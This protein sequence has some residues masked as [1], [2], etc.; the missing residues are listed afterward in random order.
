MGTLASEKEKKHICTGLLA[1]VDAGKTTLSEA[2]LYVGGMIRKLGRV[3]RGD[4]YLDTYE[5]EKKR[6]I[7]IFSKQARLLWDGMEMTILDTPGHVDFSAEMERVL[8]VL[9]Y[10]IL[11]I[12]GS[13]GVQGHTRTLWRLLA[14]YQVPV[15]LFI[16]KMDLAEGRKEALLQELRD[17]LGGNFVDF[18]EV[19]T[20]AF[21]EE[22]AVSGEAELEEFLETGM[23]SDEAIQDRIETRDL[24]PCFFGSALKNQGVEELLR[25][26]ERYGKRQQYPETFGARVFKIARD[27]QG[28]RLTYLKITGGTLKVKDVIGEEKVNQ[29]R[30]YSGERFETVSE[31]GAGCICAVTGLLKT[32]PGQGIGSCETGVEPALEPVLTYRIELPEE[33]D[34]AAMLPK[35]IQL[36]EEEPELHIAWEEEKKEIH[37][38]IMGEIQMEILKNLIAERFGVEIRFG[39]RSIVYKETIADTVEGVGHYEPLRHYAEVHLLLEPGER[40]SGLVFGSACSEDI[41]DKNWQRLVMTHLE[42][43][44]HRGVLMGAP[45]TDMKITLMSGRAHVKHTE[46]GDFRQSVYRAVRHGLRQAQSVLL[47][48]IY[49]FRLTVPERMVGRAMTDLE[50]RGGVFEAPLIEQGCAVLT[51]TAPVSLLDGYQTEVTAY[52]GG[53]GQLLCTL[54]GYGPCHNTEEVL[55]AAGYDPDTDSDNPCGSVFCSHGAGFVVPWDEV[56][57][58]MHLESCLGNRAGK[59]RAADEIRNGARTSDGRDS[60]SASAGSEESWIGTDEIDAILARTYNANKKEEGRR[61]WGNPRKAAASAGGSP[62][63][64]SRGEKALK[65]AEKKESR[66]LPEYL[67]V[68]G[69]NIIFAWDELKEMA[70]VNIDSARG[71]LQ[72]ILCDYQGS[73]GVEVIVVFDAYRVQ[74]HP[75]ELFDYHNIHVVFTKEA[76]TADQYIEKFAHENGRKYRVTVAT[77]DHLEQIIIR[78]QGCGLYSAGDLKKEIERVRAQVQETYGTAGG[79]SAIRPEGSRNYLLDSV[80]EEVLSQV[81][82]SVPENQD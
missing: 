6:G 50:R 53:Q 4:A 79:P 39:G 18:G 35:L 78:G 45:I 23:V 38:Q 59:L 22:T 19:G 26:L 9:D 15:F 3:D 76:E 70:A 20:E 28:N 57:D 82:S 36:E 11:V 5:L 67:L 77:S 49:A 31:A 2:M 27:G 17:V 81:R 62:S 13:D 63:G 51:G 71:K 42:E 74:G 55:A 60:F 43:K 1:H 29:I 16:N 61:R 24:F 12:S 8:Q 52:T 56:K 48:P 44:I 30:L 40:G 75:T 68:D 47:E 37:A 66:T 34:A 21:Y 69:Y 58:Y 10:A 54:E 65:T 7:T 14:R 46:G 41:L 64:Q 72:D 32:R 25:G 73:R 33:V 80:P